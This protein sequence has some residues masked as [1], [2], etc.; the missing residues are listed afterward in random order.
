M[1]AGVRTICTK[2]GDFAHMG[3]E[4]GTICTVQPVSVLFRIAVAWRE[5]RWRRGLAPVGRGKRP[6]S[7]S[8]AAEMPARNNPL[9]PGASLPAAGSSRRAAA[10]AYGAYPRA[11]AALG[12]LFGFA[13]AKSRDRAGRLMSTRTGLPENQFP[14]RFP[15]RK[16]E[17]IRQSIFK[18]ISPWKKNEK[19]STSRQGAR[20]CAFRRKALWSRARWI[21][22]MEGN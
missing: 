2:T 9:R 22:R 14:L 17:R 11:P 15:P 4:T 19:S 21:T 20:N 12:S 5:G 10:F 6:R 13:I 16:G 7:A 18:T 3:A 1:G 8:V